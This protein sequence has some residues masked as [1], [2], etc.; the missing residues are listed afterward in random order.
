[1]SFWLSCLIALAIVGSI[2][3]LVRWG[4]RN[5]RGS[6]GGVAMMIGLAFG[7]LFDPAKSAATESL[8]KKQ[9]MGEEEAEAG[10][11]L[12]RGE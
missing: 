10:E 4:K 6:M 9:E 7:H 11:L 3:L 5:A 2:P 8:L 12:E 1:M